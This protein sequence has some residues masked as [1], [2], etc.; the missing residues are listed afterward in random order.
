MIILFIAIYFPIE[1][2]VEINFTPNRFPIWNHLKL[3]TCPHQ[4]DKKPIGGYVPFWWGNTQE[5]IRLIFQQI[6]CQHDIN[7]LSNRR[8]RTQSQIIS[9]Y[10][11]YF[12]PFLSSNCDY[13][14]SIWCNCMLLSSLWFKALLNKPKFD[15]SFP[16]RAYIKSWRSGCLYLLKTCLCCFRVCK[17]N[18]LLG[19][20]QR[21]PWVS[22][23]CLR[24]HIDIAD[25]LFHLHAIFYIHDL[26]NKRLVCP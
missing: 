12:D 7:P 14:E 4:R 21:V 20:N 15:Q 13:S 23:Q 9:C 10:I 18:R 2:I 25:S 17:I 8:G 24:C 6:L 3:L 11:H 5:S 22:S 26:P 19:A 1:F 16:F